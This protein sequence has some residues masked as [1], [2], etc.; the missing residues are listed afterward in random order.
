MQ[1]STELRQQVEHTLHSTIERIEQLYNVRFVQPIRVHYNINSARLAGMALLRTFEIRL[2][3]AF[4]NKYKEAYIKRTVVH[5]IA[6]IGCYQVYH[7]NEGRKIS[8]HGPEWKR[9]MIRLGADS[10]R[11]HSFQADEGQGRQKTKYAYVCKTCNK[12]IPVGPKI[13]A[14]I[15][16]G[17]TY[18]SNC[19][20]V[21]LVYKGFIGAVPKQIAVQ[22]IAANTIQITSEINQKIKLP[23][24]TS[25]LGKCYELYKMHHKLKLSR[26]DMITLFVVR[27]QC[28]PA[29]ASTYLS[30]CVKLFNQEQ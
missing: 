23:D 2:N 27:C 3:P 14:N 17:R 28:T 6:H 19:C 11:C 30:T 5:E 24:P 25:K 9:M 26:V 4:L 20:K 10:S 13:H 16:K 29:G 8:A 12:P 22:R 18:V 1:V 21:Q 15:Q 7:I